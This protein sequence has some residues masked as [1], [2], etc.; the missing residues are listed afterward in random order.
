MSSR[1]VLNTDEAGQQVQDTNVERKMEDDADH[2]VI[3][4]GPF[5]KIQELPVE[6]S[7]FLILYHHIIFKTL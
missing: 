1:S 7:V 6:F 5:W 2:S 4:F 3:R